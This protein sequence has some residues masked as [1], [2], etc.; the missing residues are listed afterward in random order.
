[1][2]VLYRLPGGTQL[3]EWFGY[4][5]NFHDAEVI[6]LDLRRGLE[7]STLK[8]HA[9]HTSDEVDEDGY[10]RRDRHAT[11]SFKFSGIVQLAISDW[12]HQNVL[13]SLDVTEDSEGYVIAL[14]GTFGV[15]G[16]IVAKTLSITVEP[17]F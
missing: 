3:E 15:D 9:W 12:N 14:N 17:K 6:S 4:S 8:I 10:F 2:S 7:S 13:A 1:M 11:V 16:R 5:P